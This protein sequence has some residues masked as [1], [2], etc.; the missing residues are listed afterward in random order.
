MRVALA[1]RKQSDYK[2]GRKRANEGKGGDYH[3]GNQQ[4]EAHSR[5]ELGLV[6]VFGFLRDKNVRGI[7]CRK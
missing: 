1:G 5:R 7:A 3:D 4:K 6:A 2:T